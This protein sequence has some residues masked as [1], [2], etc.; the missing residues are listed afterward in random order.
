MKKESKLH[1]LL[2]RI[3]ANAPQ[4][5]DSP[6]II[7]LTNELSYLVKGGVNGGCEEELPNGGCSN[8]FCSNS[9]CNSTTNATNTSCTNSSCTTTG[10]S[11]ASCLNFV[12]F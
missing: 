2:A 5:T 6:G 1:L 9:Q 11:N 8:N 7:N 3:N 12:C 10:M 4:Q